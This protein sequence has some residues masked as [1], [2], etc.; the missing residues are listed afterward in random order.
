MGAGVAN[1]TGTGT[2]AGLA[3]R[4]GGRGS[5]GGGIANVSTDVV[6][7]MDTSTF[8]V[9]IGGRP[10]SYS[11]DGSETI[12]GTARSRAAWQGSRL[13]ITTSRELDGSTATQ[14]TTWS[15]TGDVLLRETPRKTFYQRK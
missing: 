9:E 11:L 3:G 8:T 5:A 10:T 12:V 4:R 14:T 7:T 13:V 6:I 1:S 2:S 15:L